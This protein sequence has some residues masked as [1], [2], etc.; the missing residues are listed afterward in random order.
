MTTSRS[1]YVLFTA[2]VAVALA[3]P[4]CAQK[5]A[6]RPPD[7]TTAALDKTGAATDTALDA[8][9]DAA[10]TAADATANA[11]DDTAQAAKNV[12][13]RTADKTKD[14]AVDVASKTKDASV[15]TGAAVTDAWITTRL[16]AKFVDEKL[17]DHSDINVDTNDHVV[18]L[19]GTVTSE[20]G[21]ARAAAIARDNEGVT[22]V[23]NQLVVK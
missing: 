13:E 10:S 23:V 14:I 8:P 20:A 16:N 7:M 6:D 4:A 15:A 12:A 22:R 21:K 17:L 19:K 9:R 11:A 3:G 2:A 5:T 1:R 18:T